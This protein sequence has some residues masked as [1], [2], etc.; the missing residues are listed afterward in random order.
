MKNILSKISVLTILLGV[1]GCQE[2][3]D[4]V[5]GEHNASVYMNNSGALINI[6]KPDDV[7]H[8]I[9]EPRL[10][11][12]TKG[13]VQITVSAIDFFPE[14]NEQNGTEYKSLP[15]SEYELYEVNNPS[16]KS[17]NGTL[18]VTVKGGDYSSKIGVRVKPLN[19]EKYPASVRYAIPLR[20]SSSS[21]RILS[22]KD[23]IVSFNRPFKTS[24]VKILKGNNITVTFDESMKRTEEFTIQGHFM[25][26]NW[27][28]MTHDWNQSLINMNG[29]KGTSNWYYTRVNKDHFQ[30][31]DLDSDGEATHIK[32]EVKLKTW[33]QL[34]FVYKDNN[35]K[36]YVNGKLAKTFVRPSLFLDAGAHIAIGNRGRIDSRD[37]H[38]REVRVW[39]KALS[40]SEI[41][42]GLYLPANPEKKE[43]LVYLPLN[44]ENK[45]KDLA[46]YKNKVSLWKDGS[47]EEVTEEQFGHEWLEN[48]KFPAEGLEIQEP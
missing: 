8:T 40:E 43:L 18:N 29:A 42:D 12:L 25:F 7:G 9:I 21:A 45:F 6:D 3:L 36:V 2:K 28:F 39:T 19:D 22:N 41:N 38:I 17:N 20:I 48:V 34:S 32:Q 30:V 47:K 44:K 23:A 16:N 4:T 15:Y 24:I 46:K 37:Y 14:Y 27:D 26:L 35:L 33:Y 10:S 31:K 13:N 1:V 11:K 5:Y